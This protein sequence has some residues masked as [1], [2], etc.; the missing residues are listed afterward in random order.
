MIDL[1]SDTVTLPSQ[2]MK[3]FMFNASLGDDVYGEDPSINLLEE[4]ASK[5]FGKDNAL[6][7]PSGTMANLISVLSH[8][9]RGEEIILGNKSHIFK[10]E[11]GG[12]SVFG[13]IHSH[14]I[15]NNDDGTLNIDD[16]I[17]SIHLND[18]SHYAITRLLCLE[19]TH[20]LCYGTP[21]KSEYF[22]DVKKVITPFN[23]SIH[24]DGA[25]IFNAAIALDESV[26]TLAETADSITCC[27]SK[28]LSCP[29]GSL[30]MGNHQFINK[31]RRLRKSLGGGM[32]QAGILA[33]AGLY[34]LDHMVDRLEEDHVNAQQLAQGL[35]EI[36]HIK[37][38]LEKVATNLVFFDLE[39]GTI[40][41]EGF[42]QALLKQDV[43]I[44]GKGNH[45]FRM[46]T[47]F[48]FINNDIEKVIKAI[49][50]I[51]EK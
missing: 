45:R 22:K 4:K 44:D 26:K 48:G 36:H 38:D 46:A 8:C 32:R 23:I 37:V 47:H 39:S 29:S 6:F 27:L 20:N 2:S 7:V 19:N 49:K 21:I 17:S 5:I 50:F 51:L 42:V 1:R 16:I 10:Y 43:K 33:A 31:A 40:S 34:A 13:G 11:A 14:Q 35:D 18:D 9:N 24:I 25:R 3:D 41:D 12:T 15:P 30:I 28:G